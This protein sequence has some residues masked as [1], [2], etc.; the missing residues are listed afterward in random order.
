MSWLAVILFPVLVACL[1]GWRRARGLT[2]N[3][4]MP[5][6]AAPALAFSLLKPAD[7]SADFPWLVLGAQFAFGDAGQIFLFSFAL[8]WTV[9][10][11]YARSYLADDP[12]RARFA[13]FFLLS[14]SGNLGVAVAQD[15]PTFYTFFA[16]MAFAAY[17]LVI[18]N[19]T[20]DA[21]R[22]A[23][24]YLVMTILGEALMLGG[25]FLA[26][27]QS[28][29]YLFTDLRVAIAQ[30]EWRNVI[31]FLLFAGFGV[32]AGALPVH[33]WLPLAHPVAPAPA[34]AVLSGAMIKAGLIGWI[35]LLPLGQVSLPGWGLFF[36]AA[37]MT[38][39][40]YA[41]AVGLAQRDAKTNLAY[42]S[43][44]QMGIMTAA[45][46][47]GLF[48]RE[49]WLPMLP[50]LAIYALN[51]GLAKG[52]LFLGA[53]AAPGLTVSAWQRKLFLAGLALA[54]LSIAGAPW[55][56]GAI[57]KHALKAAAGI[58]PA[59]W[60]PWLGLLLPLSSVATTLLL[61]RFLILVMESM[62]PDSA[63]H[64]AP[65]GLLAPWLVLVMCVAISATFAVGYFG[66]EI[67]S[68]RPGLGQIWGSLWPVLLGV[69]G[70]VSARRWL[71][72]PFRLLQIPSGDIVSPLERATR[73]LQGAWLGK[74]ILAPARW[75]INLV[76][77]FDRLLAAEA[78]R[79]IFDRSEH[80]L[81]RW[82]VA[83]LSFLLVLM[84]ALAVLSP[85]CK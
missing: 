6:A 43:V 29:S 25:F 27:G 13:F 59:F 85:G 68:A 55:T 79:G 61:T 28:A 50:V 26:A 57:A 22:A 76:E 2:V 16:V 10:A 20:S 44:S 60:Y 54:A 38:A 33:F 66:L 9:A 47:I 83:G 12:R 81:R 21:R 82:R 45:I 5:V 24:V 17:P 15:A 70:I 67:E 31:L 48:I 41:A 4:L 40:F 75:Q 42:S 78:R 37:G 73:R 62:K 19:G 30:S 39:A 8:L 18:H 84:L 63:A 46:G 58:A 23:R 11:V 32:K 7:A 52:A 65:A 80:R 56:A 64:G 49:A 71:E 53:G 74:R 69:A 51:H 3:W 1:L 72:K 35:N 34:S 77:W 14:M 36:M